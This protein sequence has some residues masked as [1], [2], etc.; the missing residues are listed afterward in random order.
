MA[1]VSKSRKALQAL[2]IYDSALPGTQQTGVDASGAPVYTRSDLLQSKDTS[3]G[4]NSVS[5]CSQLMKSFGITTPEND[6]HFDKLQSKAGDP[7]FL[8]G[9]DSLSQT[10]SADEFA[11]KLVSD[12]GRAT[13]DTDLV[14]TAKEYHQYWGRMSPAQKSIAVASIGVQNNPLLDKIVPGTEG[15][16]YSTLTGREATQLVQKGYN[17][18]PLIKNWEVLNDI[19][20]LA[21]GHSN[22]SDIADMAVGQGLLGAGENGRAVASVSAKSL[23]GTGWFSSPHQGV[24]AITGKAGSPVPADYTLLSRNVDRQMAVPTASLPTVASGATSGSLVGTAAGHNGVSDSA[25]KLYS[26]W[27]GA[28]TTKANNGVVGGSAMVSGLYAMS[29]TNPLLF[30]A[31]VAA[32][33]VD[34]KNKSMDY[35][36]DVHYLTHLG[37]T[38]LDR[39]S[40]GEKAPEAQTNVKPLLNAVD[41]SELN[42]STFNTLTTKLRAEY[43]SKG[44]KS[45]ADAYALTNQAFAEHRINAVDLVGMQKTFNMLYDRTGMDTAHK[46]LTGREKGIELAQKKGR[47]SGAQA[48]MPMNDTPA[49]PRL[50]KDEIR[51]RNRARY[52]GVARSAQPAQPAA[53]S[54]TGV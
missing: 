12:T 11:R 17:V 30:S 54:I 41:D 20:S 21:G 3:H 2:G 27:K 15:S 51:M 24:G 48:V 16:S 32:S 31:T 52:A 10:A 25:Q 9:L 19:H 39:L 50:S 29:R 6:A 45:K 47:A 8:A 5:L 43:A 38:S 46:L 37:V 7:E 13:T 26:T 28:H 53:A 18:V 14:T 33:F 40:T 22:P 34:P 42:K 44:V 4:V 1:D 49:A 35:G 23:A 36:N